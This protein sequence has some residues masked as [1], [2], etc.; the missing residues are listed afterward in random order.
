MVFA[1]LNVYMSTSSAQTTQGGYVVSEMATKYYWKEI[2]VYQVFKAN[3]VTW[4]ISRV[5][6]NLSYQ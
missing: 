5:T 6:G 4:I 1:F 2:Y 3:A